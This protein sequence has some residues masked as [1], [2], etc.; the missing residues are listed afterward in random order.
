MELG[1]LARAARWNAI[2][3]S[4]GFHLSDCFS[5]I[6][7]TI[8]SL[9]HRVTYT[10]KQDY[11]GVR[12]PLAQYLAQSRHLRDVFHLLPF[13]TGGWPLPGDEP[14]G[15]GLASTPQG[16]TAGTRAQ[17]FTGCD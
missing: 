6:I 14:Q 7:E 11:T 8:V 15:G 13:L 2:Q 5:F 3:P 9:P 1:T 4:A 16:T 12:F 17:G 10:M